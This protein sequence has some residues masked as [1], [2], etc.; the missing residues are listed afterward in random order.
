[1]FECN[2]YVLCSLWAK[3]YKT[4]VSRPLTGHKMMWVGSYFLQP[5]NVY[6]V[7]YYIQDGIQTATESSKTMKSNLVC[8]ILQ[9]L[10]SRYWHSK[11]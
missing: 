5:Y 2:S 9:W 6:E 10:D 11:I 8:S 4:S 7:W 3:T 1:M